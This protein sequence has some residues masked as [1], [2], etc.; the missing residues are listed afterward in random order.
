MR[1]SFTTLKVLAICSANR[2]RSITLEAMLNATP[3]C[4]ARSAG[5][6]PIP[7]GRSITETDLRW[8]DHIVVFERE[9]VRAIKRRFRSLFT[10][11][12]VVNLDIEDRYA[13]F[14]P[15]LIEQLKDTLAEH[16]GITLGVPEN[17]EALYQKDL[18]EHGTFYASS[19]W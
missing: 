13:P 16:W 15:A 1:E 8:A 12:H 17:A 7:A 11:L 5:T 9:H 2:C 19:R 4:E 3:G 6:H 18:E 10:T 14:D